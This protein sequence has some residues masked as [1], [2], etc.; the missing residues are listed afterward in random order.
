MA[1]VRIVGVSPCQNNKMKRKNC[2]GRKVGDGGKL[3][4]AT[5]CAILTITSR[6][7][8]RH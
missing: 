7:A 3:R 5:H 8:V 1:K 4:P 6:Y 2:G